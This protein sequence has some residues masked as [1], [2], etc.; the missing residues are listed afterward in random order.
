MVMTSTESKTNK[1][2]VLKSFVPIAIIERIK[3]N[4]MLGKV[5][6]KKK[7]NHTWK[8]SWTIFQRGYFK[9]EEDALC[10]EKV[11]SLIFN[12][13]LPTLVTDN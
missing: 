5:L 10:K 4:N 3:Q 11:N 1:N 13:N 9:N 12:S 6:R 8:S 2:K 7:K